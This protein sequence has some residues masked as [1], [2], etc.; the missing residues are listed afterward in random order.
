MFESKDTRRPGIPNHLPD[1]PSGSKSH[2]L[3][4]SLHLGWLSTALL[5]APSANS[6]TTSPS[7][8][9]CGTIRAS[10][11]RS[12]AAAA[13]TVTVNIATLNVTYGGDHYGGAVHGGADR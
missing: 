8:P 11:N 1:A 6:P 10:P 7:Q 9:S 5:P 4:A 2:T 12:V 3:P 13:D